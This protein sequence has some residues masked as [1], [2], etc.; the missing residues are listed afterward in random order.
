MGEKIIAKFSVIEEFRC[1]CDVKHK[2][3]NILILIMCAVLCGIESIKSIAEYGKSKKE[4][5]QKH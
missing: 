2:L 1:E 3:V 4:F 5:P